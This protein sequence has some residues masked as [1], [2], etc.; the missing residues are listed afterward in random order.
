M[1]AANREANV[2][3]TIA[4]GLSRRLAQKLDKRANP[5]AMRHPNPGDSQCAT[6]A[7]RRSSSDLIESQSSNLTV[8]GNFLG[9]DAAGTAAGA[10][11]GFGVRIDPPAVNATIGGP[12]PADRN[13]LSG[14][15]GGGVILPF[16]STTGHRIQGNYIGTDVTGTA[17]LNVG[18]PLGLRNIG[19]QGN[20]STIGGGAAGQGNV[21]AFNVNSGIDSQTNVSGNRITENSIYSNTALGITLLHM[22]T[23]LE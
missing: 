23:L 8:T 11:G 13:L 22:N 6:W 3:P 7:I 10:G 16:P 17:A 19:L 5:I 15:L 21:I 4:L 20:G 9:T 14:N 1:A 12:N 2:S 18:T